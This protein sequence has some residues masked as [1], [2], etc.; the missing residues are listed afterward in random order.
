MT[1]T[2]PSPRQPRK[3]R[4]I[5]HTG[6]YIDH[7]DL[8]GEPIHVLGDP[9]MDQKTRLAIVELAKA[10]RR[11]LDAGWIPPEEDEE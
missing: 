9:N 3:R 8:Q 6:F 10:A 4:T 1:K 5:K 2:K 7:P 11:Y